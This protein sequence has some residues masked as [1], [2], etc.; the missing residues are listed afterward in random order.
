MEPDWLIWARQLQAI[1]QTGLA[2]VRDPFDAERYEMIR[3]LAAQIMA[4]YTKADLTRIEELF[5]AET[6]YATPKV[7][8][9]AAAFRDDGA[10]L[11]VREANDGRWSLP[12]G[13]ADVNQSAHESVVR[14]VREEAGFD[15]RVRKLA[16]VF[17]RARHPHVP[18]RPFHVYKMFFV[19]EITGGAPRSSL[20]TT[21]IGFFPEGGLPADIS[22]SRVVPYQIERMFAHHH[23]P[24]LP[25]EFD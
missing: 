2:Y 12:G 7:D 5:A 15:I 23:A 11:M 24:H 9:R 6:G 1:A 13:W 4:S 10:L 21:E 18:L 20:E 17:D 3:T 19:C 14:E 8:V 22:I 25:T 16:A